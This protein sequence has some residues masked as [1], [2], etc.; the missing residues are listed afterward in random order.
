[1]GLFRKIKSKMSTLAPYIRRVFQFA[2]SKPK[3][4]PNKIYGETERVGV[5][6]MELKIP[7]STRPISQMKKPMS[8]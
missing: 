5:R 1:M 3:K 7:D 4:E 2:E 8:I 6:K